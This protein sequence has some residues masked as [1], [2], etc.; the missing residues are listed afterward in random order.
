MHPH[1][2]IHPPI[3]V[4][5]INY[6][7][8]CQLLLGFRGE[9]EVVP[10]NWELTN[11]GGGKSSCK[12][13]KI[14]IVIGSM[15]HSTGIPLPEAKDIPTPTLQAIHTL[16]QP[17]PGPSLKKSQ[18]QRDPPPPSPNLFALPYLSAFLGSCHLPG[19]HT[20]LPLLL[21]FPA[22]HTDKFESRAQ[23]DQFLKFSSLLSLPRKK[24]KRSENHGDHRVF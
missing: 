8:G 13:Y 19:L 20:P 2:S 12:E 18:S 9:Q 24:K 6:V 11:Y 5:S 14:T 10:W 21:K 16:A 7:W 3:H 1:S 23:L 4:P 15:S 17:S 22:P